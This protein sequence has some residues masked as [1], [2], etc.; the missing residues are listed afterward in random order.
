M[1]SGATK[2]NETSDF[3]VKRV[4]YTVNDDQTGSDHNSTKL[5]EA[6]SATDYHG[7]RSHP[8]KHH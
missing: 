7:P 1:L 5:N 2:V 4:H 3:E 8:A 6:F